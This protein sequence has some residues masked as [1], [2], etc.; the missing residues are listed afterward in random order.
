VRRREARFF[1]LAFRTH[2]VL[3]PLVRIPKSWLPLEGGEKNSTGLSGVGTTQKRPKGGWE[4]QNAKCESGVG[5]CFGDVSIN[6][7]ST[8]FRH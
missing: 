5:L 3:L 1:S 7:L 6:N 4:S 2:P 8:I